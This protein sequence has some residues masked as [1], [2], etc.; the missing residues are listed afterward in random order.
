MNLQTIEQSNDLIISYDVFN[1]FK[2]DFTFKNIGINTEYQEKEFSKISFLKVSLKI[3]N[4]FNKKLTRHSFFFRNYGAIVKY[5]CSKFYKSKCKF[6][7]IVKYFISK[8][9]IILKKYCDCDH[10]IL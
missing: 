3:C 4:R 8:D 2:N 6:E 1:K 10:H 9:F 5:R 7:I